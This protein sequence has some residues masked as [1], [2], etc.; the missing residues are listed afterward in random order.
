MKRIQLKERLLAFDAA[1]TA[2]SKDKDGYLHVAVSN[3]TCDQ[4]AGYY[5]YEI[6]MGGLDPHRIYY[7]WRAPEELTK[8]LETFNGVP[9]LIDHK[10]DGANNPQK[11]LRVGAVGTEASFTA[12]FVTNSLTIWDAEAIAAVED[13]TLRDLS[14]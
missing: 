4:V 11:Q 7:G 13:G 8:A 1:A 5:G 3:L 2:R 9:L 12:P 10:F 6:P 14:C